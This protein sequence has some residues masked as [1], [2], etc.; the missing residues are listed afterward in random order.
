MSNTYTQIHVHVVFSVQNRLSL[1]SNSWK[2]NLYQYITSIIQSNGHKVLAIGG[3]PDHIHILIGLR[4]TQALSELMKAV[5]G[6]SA[7]WINKNNF[8][9][10]QFSWQSGFGAFSY[11][12]SQIPQ[13]IQ[14]IASQEKHHKTTTFLDE[15]K[16]MLSKF[17]IDYNEWYIFKEIK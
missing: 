15:Y 17:G 3:M 12:K 10:G 9:K 11:S 5:K 6:D 14:Y 2:D 7:R 13:V 16:D 4:P 1:I 8:V